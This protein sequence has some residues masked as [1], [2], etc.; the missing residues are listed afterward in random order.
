MPHQLGTQVRSWSSLLQVLANMEAL[1]LTPPKLTARIQGMR[2]VTLGVFP[3][4]FPFAGMETIKALYLPNTL[5]RLSDL[6][7]LRGD[8]NVESGHIDSSLYFFPTYFPFAGME[9]P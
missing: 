1:S 5:L 9:T 2:E 3:T 8:G 7:P 6:L 4:Y